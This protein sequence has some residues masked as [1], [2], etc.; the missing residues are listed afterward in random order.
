[1]E[2]KLHK[3]NW[4]Q[5]VELSDIQH[6]MPIDWADAELVERAWR[7][8]LGKHKLI[9][10]YCYMAS[11][12]PDY[13]ICRKSGVKRHMLDIELRHA[14]QIITI[15]IDTIEIEAYKDN[16]NLKPQYQCERFSPNEADFLRP[17][18][19]ATTS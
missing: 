5:W 10:K 18:E 16:H 15:I 7:S 4:R 14:K 13:V 11:N 19:T 1:M 8:M 2:G 3:S 6:A 12:L 17:K 9:L